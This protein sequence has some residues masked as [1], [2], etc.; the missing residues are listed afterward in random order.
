MLL[1]HLEVQN[2]LLQEM[3]A[4]IVEEIVENVK[5]CDIS[6][7]TI[8]A[9]GTRDKSWKENFSLVLRYIKDGVVR[10]NLAAM[11]EAKELHAKYLSNLILTALEDVVP[12]SNNI[13]SQCYDGAS[14]MAGCHRGLQAL[15]QRKL[16]KSLPYT[17]CFND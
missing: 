14:V 3:A 1:T 10:E 15:I 8:K 5:Q 7:Y 9:D 12:D 6:L 4:T 16:G 17:H 13:L 2:V 11:L